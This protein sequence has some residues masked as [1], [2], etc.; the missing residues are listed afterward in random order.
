MILKHS[1]F[2]L[3]AC[4]ALSGCSYILTVFSKFSSAYTT[5]EIVKDIE[6]SG[7][8]LVEAG[9][10]LESCLRSLECTFQH[11]KSERVRAILKFENK[12]PTIIKVT[13]WGGGAFTKPNKIIICSLTDRLSEKYNLTWEGRLIEECHGK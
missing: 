10:G 11:K 4:T 6:A 3:L 1:I 2:V 12:T 5:E 7:F 8:S 13:Q 9:S